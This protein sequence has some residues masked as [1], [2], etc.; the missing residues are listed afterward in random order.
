MRVR[1]LIAFLI[2]MFLSY[3]CLS[4]FPNL[5]QIG[6]EVDDITIQNDNKRRRTE[7]GKDK[8]GGRDVGRNVLAGES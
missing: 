6:K 3:C 1:N 4:L 8:G 7:R 5:I 2:G